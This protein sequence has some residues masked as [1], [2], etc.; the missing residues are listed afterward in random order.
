MTPT[1]STPLQP[2]AKWT[3]VSVALL[4][5]LCVLWESI[6]APVK[7]LSEGFPWLTLKAAPLIPL[8]PR[9]FRGERRAF[10]ILS[11]L[12]LLYSTEGWVRAF[13]DLDPTSRTFA[14]L[15]I[16]L[17]LVIFVQ[18]NRY[19]RK[20]RSQINANAADAQPAKARAPRPSGQSQLLMYVY[21]TLL[22]LVGMSFLYTTDGS[23]SA[24]FHQIVALIRGAF[25]LLNMALLARW[26]YA[27]RARAQAAKQH[28][29]SA[30]S[31]HESH[32]ESDPSI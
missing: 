25:V 28:F 8:I 30:Q 17:S 31:D 11:L 23:E 1:A 27:G 14:W 16:A 2:L 18:A 32:H 12:I 4:C 19:A 29:S 21:A 5:M 22:C 26:F 15:E 3:A 13:S 20:T 6:G 7:P 24:R 9:L 10:Q